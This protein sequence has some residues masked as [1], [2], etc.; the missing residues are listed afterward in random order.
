[1]A[2][3]PYVLI[4]K[5]GLCPSSGDING[6]MMMVKEFNRQFK[7]NRSFVQSDVLLPVHTYIHIHTYQTRF[8]PEGLAEVSQIFLRDTHVLPAM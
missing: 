2:R 6:L 7:I 4:H 3:S 8:I 5:E 1:M